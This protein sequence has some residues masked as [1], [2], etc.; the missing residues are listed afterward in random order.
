M[1]E[2]DFSPKKGCILLPSNPSQQPKPATQASNPSQQHRNQQ[3]RNQKQTLQQRSQHH[4]QRRLHH[5]N[6]SPYSPQIK[7]QP[8]GA[9]N[10]PRNLFH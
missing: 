1:G 8:S 7:R 2:G 5:R 3:H 10:S 9:D 6:P 4:Q